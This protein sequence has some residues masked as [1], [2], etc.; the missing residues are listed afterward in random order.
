MNEAALTGTDEFDQRVHEP[1]RGVGERRKEE[2]E[3][4][5][6]VKAASGSKS[7]KARVLDRDPMSAA[8]VPRKQPASKFD[9][10]VFVLR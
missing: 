2:H 3:T 4:T 5:P 6:V 10:V 8:P 7:G 1:G 9:P